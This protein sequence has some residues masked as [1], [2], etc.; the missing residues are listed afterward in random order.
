LP[1][2]VLACNHICVILRECSSNKL[3]W[4]VPESHGDIVDFAPAPISSSVD[5]A[6][7]FADV[8][9]GGTG[10]RVAI[11]DC[12]NIAGYPTRAGCA[13]LNDAEPATRHAAIVERL[14][15]AGCN[16]VG[17]T[18]MHELAFGVTGINHWSGTP[19]NPSFPNLIPGGSSSGSAVAVASGLVDFAV[20]TDT[21]GSIRMPA[22]CC[23]IYGLKPT[24][25]RLPRS[26]LL[27]RQSTLDCVGPL[28]E[29]AAGLIAAMA[30]LDP[31]QSPVHDV[32]TVR[33]AWLNNEADR[34]VEQ[35]VGDTIERVFGPVPSVSLDDFAA[36]HHAGLT[37]IGHETANAFAALVATG[38][39]GADV[40]GRIAAGAAITEDAVEAARNTGRRFA[41]ALDALFTHYDVLALPTL[42]ALPPTLA[43]AQDA[44][45]IVPM[46]SL[47]RPFNVSGHPALAMPVGTI[48]GRPVSLQLV[49]RRGEDELLLAIAA[50]IECS[51]STET[52]NS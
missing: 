46:T 35:V 13:A 2:H 50:H 20:G 27:P 34:A 25:G 14:I 21:G 45:R 5:Q 42:P 30:A 7:F 12:I 48:S 38:R 49:A 19:I 22:A 29:D 23:G 6:I 47:C 44:S 11:K 31:Q 16:I 1:F 39:V 26:G 10:P 3:E 37:I 52:H 32:A 28:A 33:L 43:E 36:A 17:K 40:A 41:D 24:F 15:N 9:L 51:L 4:R 8:A 18:T